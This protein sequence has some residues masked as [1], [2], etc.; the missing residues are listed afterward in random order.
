[1]KKKRND[2]LSHTRMTT[3]WGALA[4]QRRRRCWLVHVCACRTNREIR[5]EKTKVVGVEGHTVEQWVKP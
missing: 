5:R 1:M 2:A 4:Q 3:S